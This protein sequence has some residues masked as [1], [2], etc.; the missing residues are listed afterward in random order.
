LSTLPQDYVNDTL[1]IV[2]TFHFEKDT[3]LDSH[4]FFVNPLLERNE[5]VKHRFY[6]LYSR[7]PEFITH[8]QH[9]YLNRKNIIEQHPYSIHFDVYLLIKNGTS[10]LE[11]GSFRYAIYFDF[12]PAFRLATVLKFPPWYTNTSLHPCTALSSSSCPPHSTCRPILNQNSSFYCSCISGYAGEN[13]TKEEACI[14]Y[15]SSNSTCLS[16][17]RG[18]TQLA[19]Q[20]LCLCPLHL[21]GS[22]CNLRNDVCDQNP[23]GLNS[24]CYLTHDLSGEKPIKCVCAK[25]FYGDY[26]QYKKVSVRIEVRLDG[27]DIRGSV[28]GFYDINLNQMDLQIQHQQVSHKLSSLIHYG[29]G[30]I[31]AP[32][33]ALLKTY[34]SGFDARYFILYMQKNVTTI[35][36]TSI[37]EQC[38][39]AQ[40]L[41]PSSRCWQLFC[42][43]YIRSFCF[44]RAN[45][46][47]THSLQ[48]S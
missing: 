26:C 47:H 30:E 35:N 10:P 7:S 31:K 2:A 21:F 24:T 44:A 34:D 1:L 48:I 19:D 39:D 28:V 27:A 17:Y 4:L 9:R 8:K 43:C 18:L 15:C 29:H 38:P 6:L 36:I 40:S 37:P 33:L 16:G 11:L 13:C 5:F 45:V 32:E 41:L 42:S 14:N 3:I 25:E 12:L 20:P 46:T 22:R 23:C